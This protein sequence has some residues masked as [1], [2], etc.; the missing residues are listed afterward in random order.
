M[1]T[2]KTSRGRLIDMG[3]LRA[4]NETTKAVG[5]VP[6]N[7]RGDIVDSR[8]NV[9]VSKEKIS[10]AYYE[11]NVPGADTKQ[12]SVKEDKVE[13]VIEVEETVT[14]DEPALVEVSRELRE[15]KDGTLYY[16]VEYAD[17]SMAE[18]DAEDE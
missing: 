15:R 13:K 2:V 9:K 11:N 5:N 14:S 17:G 12:V 1:K 10:A 3:A 8:G 4:Q 6:M 18:V 16:E 7:A